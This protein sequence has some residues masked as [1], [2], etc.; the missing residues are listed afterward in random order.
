MH[1]STHRVG[2]RRAVWVCTALIMSTSVL[3]C[4]RGDRSPENTREDLRWSIEGE[5]TGYFESP[6]DIE[7]TWLQGSVFVSPHFEIEI[8]PSLESGPSRAYTS[9]ITNEEARERYDIALSGPKLRLT[10]PVGVAQTRKLTQFPTTD[11]SPAA[12][13]MRPDALLNE[14]PSAL[15]Q[16][17]DYPGTIRYL[18]LEG[19]AIELERGQRLTDSDENLDGVYYEIFIH[20]L[21]IPEQMVTHPDG[22]PWPVG[23]YVTDVRIGCPVN[24][25]AGP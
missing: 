22:E 7:C 16:E 13:L 17:F 15:I 24:P 10:L 21:R 1:V 23:G 5:A 8:S 20:K 25:F 18:S 12:Q 3:G 14:P 2:V 19:V 9:L 11:T 6:Y 4:G